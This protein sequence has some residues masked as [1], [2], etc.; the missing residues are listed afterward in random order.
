MDGMDENGLNGRVDW[1]KTVD[2]MDQVDRMDGDE[3][4]GRDEQ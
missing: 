2:G 3:Q 4:D 1:G